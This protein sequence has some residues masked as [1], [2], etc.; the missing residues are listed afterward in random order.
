MAKFSILQVLLPLGSFMNSSNM[1]DENVK[2]TGFV[3]GSG[4]R[5]E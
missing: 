1:F 2:I 4:E 3:K 5:M